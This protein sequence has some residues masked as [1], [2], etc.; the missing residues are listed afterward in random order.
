MA[1]G[2]GGRP[3]PHGEDGGQKKPGKVPLSTH[4]KH[5]GTGR[6]D[7]TYPTP[8]PMQVKYFHHFADTDSDPGSLHHTLG[9]GGTQASP[10]DHQHDGGSSP[11]LLDGFTVSGQRPTSG[12]LAD[13]SW[14]KSIEAAL[15][16]LGSPINATD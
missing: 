3:A 5:E 9:S 11:T 2:K 6:P 4:S 10:G 13:T 15:S 16:R 12:S 7:G 14:A 8:P 1:A